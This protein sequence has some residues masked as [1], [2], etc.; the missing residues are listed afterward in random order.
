MSNELSGRRIAFLV[1]NAGVEQIELTSPWQAV[2][3]A[4]GQ[5]VLLAPEKDKV[6]AVNHDTD[7]A[8]T[9]DPDQAVADARAVD[10]FG[11]RRFFFLGRFFFFRPFGASGDPRTCIRPA[12]A[13][14]VRERP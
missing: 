12:R 1:A 14:A 8:G 11:S 10:A 3:D 13:V 5:P 6:Q 4:G 7:P 2:K 9:F